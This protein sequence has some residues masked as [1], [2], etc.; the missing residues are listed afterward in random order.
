MKRR[1]HDEQA[2]RR[3]KKICR[4]NTRQVE[5]ARAL[6]MNPKKLPG[7]RPSPQQRWKL[8]VGE[9]IEDRYWKR[10]GGNSFDPRPQIPALGSRK[11]SGPQRD[12]HV[13]EPLRDAARQAGDLVC[14]LM[15]LTD[16]L[17]KWLAEGAVAPEVLPQVIEELRRIAE[18]LNTG[19]P[20][21]PIPAIPLP[22]CTTRHAFSQ[23]GDQERMFNDE[24]PF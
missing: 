11:P 2:W 10:F 3:A 8:P 9:F 7:L 6:G 17:Q 4:L 24:I 19:T 14:Y 5:M 20:I 13:P 22:P 23:R 1:A 15:N 16:D 18:A 12:A 21:S